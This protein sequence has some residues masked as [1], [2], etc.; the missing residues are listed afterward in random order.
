MKKYKCPAYLTTDKVI[1]YGYRKKVLRMFCKACTTHFSMNTTLNKKQLLRDHLNGMSF[2]VLGATYGIS[3]T[4]AWEVCHEELEKVPANNEFTHK[5]CARFSHIFLFD[6]KYI[7]VKGYAGKIPLLWGIDY[8]THDIPVF[9]LAPS[10][11]YQSWARY[12]S[13]FRIISHHPQLL[14]CDDNVNIKM[15]AR[16]AFPTVKIQTC[17]NHFKE[18]VRRELKVRTDKTYLHFSSEVD[19]ILSHKLSDEVFNKWMGILFE[20]YAH[21][22]VTLSILANIEKYKKELLAYR[23]IKGAP[24]TTNLIECFNSHLQDRLASLK[25]F[26]SFKHATL[27]LNAYILKRRF[28]RLSGCEGKFRHLNGERPIDKTK[29]EKLVL[30]T[31]F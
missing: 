17:T 2:Q 30:P 11:N 21:D 22:P 24:T 10:E 5:Y 23:G 20:D 1:R 7:H 18:N 25:G 26:E 13:F 9:T 14:V 31:L 16:N 12:F 15:A 4:Q 27:W 28:T 6:G 3:K 19:S 8:F 29:N